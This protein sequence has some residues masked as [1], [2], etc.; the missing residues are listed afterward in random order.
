VDYSCGDP[1]DASCWS[2]EES[3]LAWG[4]TG[5]ETNVQSDSDGKANTHA[6]V[7][8]LGSYPAAQHCYDLTEGGVPAGTWYLPAKDQLVDALTE[9]KDSS[10]G[11]FGD[12]TKY[13]SS[14]ELSASIAWSARYNSYS[15]IVYKDNTFK[16]FT[17]YRVRCLR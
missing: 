3:G 16:D 15:G 13:W 17:D 10:E 9:F 2:D 8:L 12:G 7:N 6:L 4:P 5:V 1:T 14:T 11:G